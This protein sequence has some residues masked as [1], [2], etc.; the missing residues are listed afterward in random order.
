MSPFINHMRSGIFHTC[1]LNKY[2]DTKTSITS[3]KTK[4]FRYNLMLRRKQV[5]GV[6]RT[7]PPPH[8]HTTHTINNVYRIII[9]CSHSNNLFPNLRITLIVY[10][11][12]VFILL[13]GILIIS[14]VGYYQTYWLLPECV[15]GVVLDA[16]RFCFVF[17][18]ICIICCAIFDLA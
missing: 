15:T 10:M 18:S 6:L 8:T 7:P 9:Y 5:G 14:P 13:M 16:V 17:S 3:V 4:M 2:L 11:M 12:V 1:Y